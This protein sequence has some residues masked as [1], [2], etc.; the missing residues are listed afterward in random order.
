MAFILNN[1]HL[2]YEA[3]IDKRFDF[4]EGG[5]RLLVDA[6]PI[7]YLAASACES[8][9]HHI[10][11]NDKSTY[12][13]VGGKTELYTALGFENKAQFELMLETNPS[14]TY[15]IEVRTDDQKNMKHTIK[16]QVAKLVKR[17][18]A[19]SVELYLTDSKSNFRITEEIATILKYKGNR[20]SDS[21]PKLLSE[22]RNYLLE[23]LDAIMCYGMEADDKLAIEHR[24]AWAQAMKDA[25]EFYIGENVDTE[26][27]EKKA[28]ELTTT[29]LASIDK[30]LKQ[31]AGKYINP[32]EDLGIEEIFPLGHM[33]LQEK[34]K[35]KKLRFN[36]LKAFYAQIIIGDNC[37]NIPSVYFC[38]DTKAYEVLKD[39]KNEEE[40]FKAALRETYEGFHREMI[41]SLDPI[42]DGKVE[43]ALETGLH[44]NDNKSNRTKLRKKFK[45][46]YISNAAY[47]DKYYYPW[48]CYVENEDGTVSKELKEGIDSSDIQTI[49]P[50]EHMIEVARLVYMLEKEPCEDGSH[51]WT[52]PNEK[53]IKDVQDEYIEKNLLRIDTE[54]VL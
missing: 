6:D 51:L 22:A 48:W 40:L 19:G 2:D 16:R 18:G 53:W 4:V 26:T 9:T 44:G 11:I 27:L 47:K 42:I 7:A 29:V 35:S 23:E 31:V 45:D 54:W 8:A 38:G 25:E 24:K 5:L 20:S 17:V 33:F 50:I 46:Y 41:K 21:K 1:A 52:P 10:K 13:V 34:G 43:T 28:M 49:S 15:E 3:N 12:Q 14:I 39:C 32:D 37:D 30:D 36:G